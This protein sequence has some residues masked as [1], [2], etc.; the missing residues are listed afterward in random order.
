M[1]R[2]KEEKKCTTT[3]AIESAKAGMTD[4][5]GIVG[6]MGGEGAVVDA[7][8]ETCKMVTATS[9]ELVKKGEKKRAK[10]DG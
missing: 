9:R 4:D 3:G 1:S 5:D 7:R 2:E 6:G 10:P 8:K